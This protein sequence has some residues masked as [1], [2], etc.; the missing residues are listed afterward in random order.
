MQTQLH[1]HGHA[2]FGKGGFQ[3]SARRLAHLR[4]DLRRVGDRETAAIEP[5]QTQ[6]VVKGLRMFFDVGFG[7]K[8]ASSSDSKICQDKI[9]RRCESALSVI[10]LPVNCLR[11]WARV[12]APASTGKTRLLITVIPQEKGK[13]WLS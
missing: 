2:H 4:F 8:A 1:H 12:P 3:A 7:L 6:A 5:A 9:V 11:C 10:D 13:K